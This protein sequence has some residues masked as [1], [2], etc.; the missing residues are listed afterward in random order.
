MTAY[1]KKEILQSCERNNSN[2]LVDTMNAH[3]FI[4]LAISDD[5]HCKINDVQ[6]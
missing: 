3:H 6:Y 2:L 4:D 5:I 1:K